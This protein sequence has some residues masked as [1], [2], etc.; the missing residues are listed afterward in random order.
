M[1]NESPGDRK[2]LPASDGR[3]VIYELT[4]VCED[5]E[6]ACSRSDCPSD[7]ERGRIFEA[8]RIRRG[9]GAWFHEETRTANPP[10][11]VANGGSEGGQRG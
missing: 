2:D 7:F 1:N 8:K 5:T 4:A 9:M 11:F 10:I 6:E 3:R